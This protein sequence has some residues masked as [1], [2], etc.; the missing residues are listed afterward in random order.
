MFV[1]YIFIDEWIKETDMK[2]PNG[3]GRQATVV[4]STN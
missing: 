3:L 1:A 2:N 4:L